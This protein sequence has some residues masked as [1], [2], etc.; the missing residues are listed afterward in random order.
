MTVSPRSPLIS[1][2]EDYAR[3]RFSADSTGHDWFHIDRVR[4]NALA[5]ARVEPGE[6]NFLLVEVSALLHEV[7]DWKLMP[8]GDNG[9]WDSLRSS[10]ATGTELSRIREIIGEISF[11]GAGVDTRPATAEG[12]IVQDADRL[13]ALGAI[14]VAR[15]FAYG[16]KKGQ[17][18]HDPS[19]EPCLHQSFAA[20]RKHTGTSINHFYEKLLLL[21]DL[22]NTREGRRLALVRH[23]FMEDFLARFGHE[24]EGTDPAPSTIRIVSGGQTGVDRAALDAALDRYLAAGGWCPHGRRSEDGP[25]DS[26]YPVQETP[27]P[28]PE[29]RTEWNVRDSD[30]TLILFRERIFGGT[31]LTASLA[32]RYQR[33]C[34]LVDL[35]ENSGVES[36]L[37]WLTEH[38]IRV[39]N[40]AGPRASEDSSIY[41]QA[42]LYLDRLL[43]KWNH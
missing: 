19:V 15:A 35:Q 30:G 11:K 29:Q 21:R 38:C 7:G 25:L 14:G 12:K 5:I 26:R 43:A 41:G 27:S 31:A 40:I 39:L 4:R 20:Y 13:D 16:G 32:E 34:L 22:M 6:A 18:I 33:P 1:A 10:G 3:N 24:W 8:E 36:A 28:E 23:R 17:P 2:A 37:A 42:R 9:V